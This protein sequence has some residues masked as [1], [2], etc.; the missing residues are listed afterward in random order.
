MTHGTWR[1]VLVVVCFAGL[2][3]LVVCIGGQL[4]RDNRVYR[5]CAAVGGSVENVS[6]YAG[7]PEL[8]CRIPD[9]EES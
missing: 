8:F 5:E 1:R 9:P 3:G 6:P 2:I 4:V 7:W